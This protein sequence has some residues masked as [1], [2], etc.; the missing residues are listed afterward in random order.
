MLWWDINYKRE[1]QT[2]RIY[3]SERPRKGGT[4]LSSWRHTVG[5]SLL[6]P[7]NFLLSSQFHTLLLP[8][9]QGK[10]DS[11]SHVGLKISGYL[12][13]IYPIAFPSL[14]LLAWHMLSSLFCTGWK[15]E[16]P[17]YQQTS[18]KFTPRQFSAIS[19]SLSV[20]WALTGLMCW[21]TPGIQAHQLVSLQGDRKVF[22]YWGLVQSGDHKHLCPSLRGILHWFWICLA[23]STCLVLFFVCLFVCFYPRLGFT[24]IMQVFF[25]VS[26]YDFL[27]LFLL[28]HLAE[29]KETEK[30]TVK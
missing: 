22:Q 7:N 25:K 27:S 5:S 30:G 14:L 20:F 3:V 12:A 16:N 21:L 10:W 17:S 1:L 2:F 6:F 15:S 8:Q 11:L 29:D 24:S 18:S 4:F 19:V 26:L 9:E 28:P 23:K 13:R